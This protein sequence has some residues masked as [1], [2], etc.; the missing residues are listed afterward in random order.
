MAATSKRSRWPCGGIQGPEAP[1]N[2]W[3]N[4]S[5]WPRR[6]GAPEMRP[7]KAS[8]PNVCRGTP[9]W[10]GIDRVSVRLPSREF[11]ARSEASRQK[12]TQRGLRWAMHQSGVS[13]DAARYLPRTGGFTSS[14]VPHVPSCCYLGREW[15]LSFRLGMRPWI[16]VA[17]SAPVMAATA[18]FVIY[19]ADR[20]TAH[21][22]HT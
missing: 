2:S 4:T 13:L 12:S 3:R 11:F 21:H 9:L 8:V 22:R 17:Y 19:P 15:E 1:R 20:V 10:C 5:C 14:R 7:M 18:V 16:A 6:E